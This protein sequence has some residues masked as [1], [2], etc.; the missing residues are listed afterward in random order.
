MKEV[1]LLDESGA[2]CGRCEK[3]KAH[4]DGLYH[5][6]Y[7]VIIKD[8]KGNMLL[9]RRAVEKYHSGGKW[10]NACCSHPDS[11]EPEKI[12][13]HAK[14]RMLEELG[15]TCEIEP[16]TEFSYRAVVGELVENERDMVFC[17]EYEGEVNPDAQEV[18]D[19][20]WVSPKELSDWTSS[21]PEDFSPWFLRFLQI[22]GV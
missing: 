11:D 10:S 12:K 7:S 1:L 19:Y 3:Q 14:N 13:E 15:F 5:L 16:L 4:I 2:V 8:T 9:Q 17:G 6:A 20:R 22:I 18:C 21:S